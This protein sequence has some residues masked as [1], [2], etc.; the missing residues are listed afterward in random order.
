MRRSLPKIKYLGWSLQN[1]W[2]GY[3]FGPVQRCRECSHTTPGHLA[4]CRR[5]GTRR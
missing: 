2:K 4:G 3:K 1:W 5:G